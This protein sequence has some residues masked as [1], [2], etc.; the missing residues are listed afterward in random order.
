M[1]PR[2]SPPRLEFLQIPTV[3][4]RRNAG[5]FARARSPVDGFARGGIGRFVSSPLTVEGK[6][7]GKLA[8][9]STDIR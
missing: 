5:K 3:N 8:S 4:V 6:A 9:S 2:F 7:R 1:K